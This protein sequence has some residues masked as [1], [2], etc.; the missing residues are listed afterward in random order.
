MVSKKN[1]VQDLHRAGLRL[2]DL[3]VTTKL[4]GLVIIGIT[5]FS[6]TFN[7][8]VILPQGSP[9]WHSVL[10][11]ICLVGHKLMEVSNGK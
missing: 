10:P 5:L 11:L 8:V 1:P 9:T 3:K 7:C 6:L 2:I 4:L